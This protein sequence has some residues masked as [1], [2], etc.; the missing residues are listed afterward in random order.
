[1]DDIESTP[2]RFIGAYDDKDH[3]ACLL[4]GVLWKAQNEEPPPATCERCGGTD[5]VEENPDA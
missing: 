1:M 5:T 2:F 3:Y 4:C